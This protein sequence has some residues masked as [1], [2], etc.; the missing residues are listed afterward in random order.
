MNKRLL[1]LLRAKIVLYQVLLGVNAVFAQ[2]DDSQPQ[3]PNTKIT[4]LVA[5][6]EQVKANTTLFELQGNART[7]LTGERTALN[8]LQTLSGTATLTSQYVQEL[9]GSNTKLLDTRKTLPG[10]EVRKN[11]PYCVV[12]VLITELGCLMPF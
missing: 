10:L 12:V 11:M 4:W 3:V 8:F 9:S 5:D 1:V 7:L 6:G 2:L